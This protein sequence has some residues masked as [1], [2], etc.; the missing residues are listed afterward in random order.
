MK[1][2]GAICCLSLFVY[3]HNNFCVICVHGISY[4][5]LNHTIDSHVEF[6]T[7]SSLNSVSIVLPVIGTFIT[8]VRHSLS[9]VFDSTTTNHM[10]FLEPNKIMCALKT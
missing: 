7:V 2:K 5:E 3:I 9:Q 4:T 6:R 1:L 8:S 10:T